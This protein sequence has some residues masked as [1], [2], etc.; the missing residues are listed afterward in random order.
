[1]LITPGD[2]DCR[3]AGSFFKNPVLSADQYDDLTRRAAVKGLQ[4]P[5]YPALDAQRKF[6]QPGWWSTPAS[7]KAIAAAGPAF[8]A[9][10]RWP[11]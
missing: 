4:I 6:P 9:S 3:S 8:R 5:S 2:E 11:S 7:A 10:M 1:M